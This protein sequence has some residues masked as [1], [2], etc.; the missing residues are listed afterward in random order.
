VLA[1]AGDGDA[2]DEQVIAAIAQHERCDNATGVGHHP[3]IARGDDIGVVDRDR[4]RLAADD[5]DIDG[6]GVLRQRR[7]GGDVGGARAADVA[8]QGMTPR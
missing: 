8:Y 4:F 7:D 2:P 5:R 1:I 6:I 3:R